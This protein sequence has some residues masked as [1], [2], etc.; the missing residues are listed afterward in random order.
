MLHQVNN[1]LEQE[2]SRLSASLAASSSAAKRSV[3]QDILNN[4]QR[5]QRDK[6]KVQHPLDEVVACR[7]CPR[8][9]NVN[10]GWFQV[11]HGM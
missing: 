8:R 4:L 5:L 3:L 10:V 6:A 1:R 7:L 9:P 2:N 11:C